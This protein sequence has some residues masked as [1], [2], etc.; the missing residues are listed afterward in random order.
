MGEHEDEITLKVWLSRLTP[1]RYD[2][3]GVLKGSCWNSNLERMKW[4]F[5]FF[6][7]MGAAGVV[8]LFYDLHDIM[9]V[10]KGC[11]VF[12]HRSQCPWWEYNNL[13]DVMLTSDTEEAVFGGQSPFSCLWGMAPMVVTRTTKAMSPV[14]M[15]DEVAM[16]MTYATQF[17]HT[18][19]MS[20]RSLESCPEY[21][22]HSWLWQK[23][24]GLHH[25][26]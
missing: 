16:P 18:E 2:C 4:G 17:T 9:H 15:T 13:E 3:D 19:L 20:Q 22:W 26:W 8:M 23:I 1:G 12:L 24:V 7:E 11:T 25:E 10:C 14:V 5:T 21:P 6:K